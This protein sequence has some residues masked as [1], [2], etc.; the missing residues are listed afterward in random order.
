MELNASQ[1]KVVDDIKAGKKIIAMLAPSYIVDFNYPEII[2]IL[3]NMGIDKV[4]ELTFGAKMINGAYHRILRTHPDKMFI[5]SACPVIVTLVKTKYQKYK[6]NLVP[7][8]S[9]L[10][11]TARILKKN[12]SKHDLLFISPCFAKKSEVEQYKGLIK[13]VLTYGELKQL[14]N[15][16]EEKKLFKKKSKHNTFDKFYNDYTKI[17]PLSGGLSS[18][19]HGKD[20]LSKDEVI[21]LEGPKEVDEL[22]SKNIPKK[23]KFLDLLYCF[24]GCIGGPGVCSKEKT[25]TK[26]D[27]VVNYM[28]HC[29]KEKEGKK[30]G[31]VKYTKGVS[32]KTPEE[33]VSGECWVEPSKNTHSV[34]KKNKK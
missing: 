27:K 25:K 4:T 10:V 18:T 12:Y 23:I 33:Y 22:L 26:H 19:M 3:R 31:L 24:G 15:Y 5:S 16:F 6:Q 13:N 2:N 11:A 8:V 32:F 30:E 7:V 21:V 1:Q 9:P 28:N 14:I 29:R 34:K 17:Y 20:I